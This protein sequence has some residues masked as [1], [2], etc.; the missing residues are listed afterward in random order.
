MKRMTKTNIAWASLGLGVFLTVQLLMGAGVI[1]P[2]HR[3]T[4]M[5]ICINMIL[6]LGLNLIIG[7]TGQFSL[8][9]AGFMAIGAYAGGLF[10]VQFAKSSLPSPLVFFLG[11]L[12]GAALAALVAIIIAIPTLRLTGDYLAIATL[13]TSEIIRIVILNIPKV[14]KGAAG[15]SNLPVR[16]NWSIA[17]LCVAFTLLLI[18]NFIYSS[19]GRAC[20]AIR[21]DEI[22]AQS[23][24]IA[25]TKYKTIAFVIGAVTA[26]IAGGLYA[27]TFHVIKPGIFDFNKSIDILIIV[28][29]GGM[30]NLTG[31]MVAAIF[32]GLINTALQ[33][34]GALRMIIYAVSI[35]AIMVFKPGGLMGKRELR[36]G[37]LFT[38]TAK[39]GK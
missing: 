22:A 21:E 14:T 11:L 31:T 36:L 8:G 15:L 24:G 7:F 13:G 26:S 4:I 12:I 6:G 10:S 39:E 2:Y 29:F 23:V 20:I 33:T 30:G 3:I 9:H 34:L 1:T 17:F 37:A 38:K 35:I 16:T 25:T 18:A 28:V 5:N 32:L 19:P 27:S